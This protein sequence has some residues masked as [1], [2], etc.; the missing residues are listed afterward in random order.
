M[1]IHDSVFLAPGCTVVGDVEIGENSSVWYGAV[2]RGDKPIRIG[3]GCSIQ[4]NA[5][6][7]AELDHSIHVGDNVTIGHGAIVHGC[8]VGDNTLVG[9]GAIILNDAVVGKNCII[10]AGALVTGKKVI[11]DGSLVMGSPA[12]IKR[13][14]TQEE[15]DRNL[16]NAAHYVEL[17]QQYKAKY[18]G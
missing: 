8:T 15:L 3:K 5:V 1:K 10:G 7:H 17:A 6:F 11:P 18:S 2:I 16:V 12:V 4:D 9:M 13:E 14:V